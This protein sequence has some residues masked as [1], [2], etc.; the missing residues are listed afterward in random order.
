MCVCVCDRGE[1]GKGQRSHIGRQR[2]GGKN[3]GRRLALVSCCS[4]FCVRFSFGRGGRQQGTFS[5]GGLIKTLLCVTEGKAR[6][7]EGQGLVV[8]VA[9]IAAVEGL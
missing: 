1:D 5:F 7:G 9:T 6:G 8:L 4:N 3:V 2:A